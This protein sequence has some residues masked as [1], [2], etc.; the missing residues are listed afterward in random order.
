MTA[1]ELVPEIH[2]ILKLASKQKLNGNENVNPHSHPELV[3]NYL[4]DNKT[5][6]GVCKHHHG[7]NFQTFPD[8]ED[9]FILDIADNLAAATSRALRL[10]RDEKYR[11]DDSVFKLW[12]NEHSDIKEGR[13]LRSLSLSEIVEFVAKN[14]DWI[15]YNNKYGKKLLQQAE[16]AKLGNNVTSLYTHSKLSGQ[17]YRILKN[18][19]FY[20]PEKGL[21]DREKVN[22]TF[23]NVV[24]NWKLLI[25]NFK[26]KFPQKSFRT[27][28]VNV[29]KI[30]ENILS[31]IKNKYPDNVLFYTSDEILMISNDEE[32]LN[33]IK[34]FIEPYGFWFKVIRSNTS[35]SG[36]KSDP[37][38]IKGKREYNEYLDLKD[39]ISPPICEICQMY[40][41]K[42]YTSLSDDEKKLVTD[43]KSGIIENLC[44]SCTN[45]RKYGESL[46]KLSKWTDTSIVWIKIKLDFNKLVKILE[47]LYIEYLKS[48]N[49]K[50]PERAEIR[51]SVVNEF[52]W[53][54]NG[55]LNQLNER[56]HEIFDSE[57]EKNVEDVLEDLYCV[58]IDRLEDIEKILRLYNS[59]VDEFFQKFKKTIES[60][61]KL[62]ISESNV[63]F[64][65]F[66][67]WKYLDNPENDIDI[68][69]I[70]KGE[71]KVKLSQLEDLLYL[72]L[73]EKTAL[74]KLAN[75]AEISKELAYM[76]II[77]KEGMKNHPDLQDAIFKKGFEIPDILTFVKI[78]G[79]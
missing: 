49:V 43:D 63:K 31:E 17:F 52:Q 2:D 20:V 34:E 56:L 58:K 18:S 77:S 15:D 71:M 48:L 11:T 3:L 62:V 54:Y 70:G 76:E 8:T 75:M 1:D 47:K 60:P 7:E 25:F 53:D 19:D 37:S 29:L 72:K 50:N 40:P 26:L 27:K 9:L 42:Q 57:N 35:L 24:K 10:G 67:H 79:G 13:E 38:Q 55:F 16:D 46:K 14:P 4:K 68:K 39:K 45:I 32:I 21:E 51:Y 73:G 78:K 65:F 74:N 33:Q 61:I 22:E 64:P 6:K 23:K 41:A 5:W 12:K 66:E 44:E 36:L 69:I 28:D 30:L 59:L